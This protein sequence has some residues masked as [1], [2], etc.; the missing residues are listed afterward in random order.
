MSSSE[1]VTS[2]TRVIAIPTADGRLSMHFGHCDQFTLLEV[3]PVDREILTV[4]QMTPPPHQ[5]R[6]W[7]VLAVEQHENIELDV[8]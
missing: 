6:G 1:E 2:R 3:D 4:R 7:R 5:P 8:I